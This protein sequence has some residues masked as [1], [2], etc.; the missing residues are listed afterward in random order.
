MFKKISTASLLLMILVLAIVFPVAAQDNNTTEPQIGT[1]ELYLGE[2]LTEK[3]L[4]EV[5]NLMTFY[6]TH[7]QDYD[8]EMLQRTLD[9]K[10]SESELEMIKTNGNLLLG[11]IAYDHYYDPGSHAHIYTTIERVWWYPNYNIHNTYSTKTLASMYMRVRAWNTGGALLYNNYFG[12]APA[13][14]L[15]ARNLGGSHGTAQSDGEYSNGVYT[16][17]RTASGGY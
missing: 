10:F 12:F 9:G 8:A 14:G 16:I 13:S 4:S 7:N 2:S 17:Y 5:N 11:T 3:E 1:F 6:R 15:Y